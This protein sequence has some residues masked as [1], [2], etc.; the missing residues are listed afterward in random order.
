MCV[1]RSTAAHEVRRADVQ[2]VKYTLTTSNSHP[3]RVNLKSPTMNRPPLFTV[4]GQSNGV[5]RG[6]PVTKCQATSRVY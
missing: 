1:T 6:C 3:N 5:V 4:I 2:S